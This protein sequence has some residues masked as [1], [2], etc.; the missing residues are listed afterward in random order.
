MDF[1]FSPE[2]RQLKDSLER[3]ANEQYSLA[4][5]RHS[6]SAPEGWSRAMWAKLAGLGI[7]R[8]PFA[9]E[10]G[11][12]GWGGVELMIVGEAFGRALI[13]E[14]YLSSIVLAGTAVANAEQTASAQAMLERIMDGEAIA[15]LAV[16]ASIAA[17]RSSSGWRLYGA[18]AQVLGAN[19]ADI[20][21]IAVDD[22]LFVLPADAKGLSLRPYSLHG[23]GGAAALR[24]DG[25][26]VDA[27]MRMQA[28]DARERAV[29]A[30][31]CF[32][33]AEALGAMAGALDVTI[34]HL[35]TRVQFAAPLGA[36]QALQHRAAEMLVEVEQARSAAIL[37]AV[38]LAEQDAHTRARG[39]AA[40]KA[41]AGKSG[42]FVAQ[43]AVQLHGG[44]G[45]SE[46]HIVSHYFRRLTALG[47]LF[48]ASEA[49]LARL[50][51]LGG[52]TGAEEHL[53]GDA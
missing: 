24:L 19:A 1:D 5:R 8:L 33:V 32:V 30:G 28:P 40:A 12:L 47:L 34:E 2:Q 9:E 29:E 3:F 50:A 7:G 11:G 14:P 22:A 48:G 15:A 39:L 26:H 17:T 21:V 25:V 31:L 51:S 49:Q 18:A 13:V 20:I 44:I 43:N 4:Q 27:P 6:L 53:A 10:R 35:K 37:A 41:V 36:N 23:G 45:V 46:E 38:A 42:R 52:F 16:E